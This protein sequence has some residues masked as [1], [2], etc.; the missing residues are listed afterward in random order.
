MDPLAAGDGFNLWPVSPPGRFQPL[1]VWLVPTSDG[2]AS[3]PGHQ[4][5]A[6]ATSWNSSPHHQPWELEGPVH[7]SPTDD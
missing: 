4:C 6:L 2:L 7:L 1:M 5:S 3:P